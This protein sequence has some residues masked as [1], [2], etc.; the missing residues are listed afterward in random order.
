MGLLIIDNKWRRNIRRAAVVLALV[1]AFVAAGGGAIY[2]Y[3][4]GTAG[5]GA[6]PAA[7]APGRAP[8]PVSV[9]IA[10]RRDVPIYLTGL[11]T[12][13]PTLSVGIHSQVDGK[14]QE[15]LFTEG[16]HV[17]KGD[18]IAKID[19]RLFKAALDQ[20]MA[21]K[22]QDQALLGSAQKDLTR[23]KTLAAKSFESQQNVDQQQGKVDQLTA[24]VEA[25]DAA[26][27][28]AQTQLDYT[29]ITAPS[30][31][32]IG[33]RLVDP[34]NVV[35]ASDAGAIVSLVQAQPAAV[36]FTLPS[37]VLDDV[38]LAMGKG[39]IEVIA[40]DQDNRRPLST[41]SLLTVDNAVDQAT[42]TIRLKAIFPNQDDRL[43]PGEFV[44]ARLRLETRSNALVVPSSAIQRGPQG[45]FAW[46]VTADD[47][48]V[49][50]QIQ[51]G[52][53]LGDLTIIDSGINEGDRVVTEGQY[54]LQ[55]N[56]PVTVTT[57]PAAE[58]RRSTM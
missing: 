30:D 31:G 22:A 25:D 45:L 15:V 29:T 2:W 12:V 48:A 16:Q 18:V 19:P 23:F 49:V 57:A 34:G 10:A 44:N 24:M 58:A 39:A 7:R 35:R 51:V 5:T 21:K 9:A 54:K 41:G 46:T 37:R 53:T 26:I 6:G 14:L 50:R 52:S 11:G 56:A 33:V 1:L 38:R 43:W 40:F 36:M 27:E 42:A 47:K 13:Q 17:K 3:T 32:R 28:T 4:G 20:A 55:A 8:V